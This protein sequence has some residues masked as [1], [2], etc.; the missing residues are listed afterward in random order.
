MRVTEPWADHESLLGMLQRGRGRG[1]QE[2]S[3]QP[4]GAR[5]VVRCIQDDCRWDDFEER[6]W[7]F[8]RLMTQLQIQVDSVACDL[9]DEGFLRSVWCET[10]L[11]LATSGSAPAA[12]V[13]HSYVRESAPDDRVGEAVE[14]IWDDGG[15][16]GREG[17]REVALERLSEDLLQSSAHPRADGPWLAWSDVPMISAALGA[18][19]P[20]PRTVAPDLSALDAARLVDAVREWPP[21]CERRAALG[22]LARR[23]DV[24]LLELAEDPSIR[25]SYGGVPALDRALAALGPKALARAREWVTADDEFLRWLAGRLLATLGD[26]IDGSALIGLLDEA[27]DDGDWL[28]TE[29]LA[30]GLGRIGEVKATPSLTRAWAETLHSHARAEYLRSLVTLSADQLPSLYA[31]AVDDCESWVRELVP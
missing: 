13:L 9:S 22:E 14:M 12:R 2:V 29:H 31:E 6:G 19:S 7:Y 5:L 24:V 23:A 10:L 30:A 26:R 1:L 16:L 18:W 25:N 11:A 17:L 4:E 8:G 20:T 21:G 15:E 28:A 3:G 27:V